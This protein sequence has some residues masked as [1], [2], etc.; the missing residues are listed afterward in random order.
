MSLSLKSDVF[1]LQVL[2]ATLIIAKYSLL[3]LSLQ[4]CGV[5]KNSCDV[6]SDNGKI[7]KLYTWAL[8]LNSEGTE[9][10]KLIMKEN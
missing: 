3:A 7:V 1:I 5:C 6:F 10:L 9:N 8:Y 2:N 4:K